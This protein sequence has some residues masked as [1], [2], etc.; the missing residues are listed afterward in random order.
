MAREAACLALHALAS[1]YNGDVRAADARAAA[2]AVLT[3][4]RGRVAVVAGASSGGRSKFWRVP[5]SPPMGRAS[6]VCAVRSFD[7]FC[8][9][10]VEA[11]VVS[12]Q[13]FTAKLCLCHGS[14]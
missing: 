14:T 13:S 9:T 12:T 2:W 8:D 4:A 5:S 7:A 3:L 6:G 10:S 1:R 11:G